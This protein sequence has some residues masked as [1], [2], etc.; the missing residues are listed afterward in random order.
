METATTKFESV[1]APE[2]ELT[3]VGQTVL[4]TLRLRRVT[5]LITS[6][7]LGLPSM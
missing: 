2:E 1:L 4:S 7:L 3:I 6:L 5:L